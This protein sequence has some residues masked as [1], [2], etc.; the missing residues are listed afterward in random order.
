MV[1]RD[2]TM[3]TGTFNDCLALQQQQQQDPRD[4]P[5]KTGRDGSL[6]TSLSGT[7]GNSHLGSSATLRTLHS[8]RSSSMVI[9]L[10]RASVLEVVLWMSNCSSKEQGSAQHLST[11]REQRRCSTLLD[12]TGELQGKSGR[13]MPLPLAEYWRSQGITTHHKATG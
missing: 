9:S 12:W 13:I 5:G 4:M 10:M 2:L 7:T 8:S 1:H 6:P 3:M 11:Q